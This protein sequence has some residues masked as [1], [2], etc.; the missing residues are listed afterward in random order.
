MGL[1]RASS[2]AVVVGSST[3]EI[4]GHDTLW[5]PESVYP[6]AADLYRRYRKDVL[7]K[8]ESPLLVIVSGAGRLDLS[9]TAFHTEGQRVLIVTSE[10]GKKNLQSGPNVSASVQVRAVS[11][12][13]GRLAPSAILKLLREEFNVKLALNE[14]GPTLFGQFLAA[15]L[16]DELFLTV[17]PQ[18]AGRIPQ[19][20]R[21]SFVEGVDFLPGNA[22]WWQLLSAKQAGNHLYLH[23]HRNDALRP[24]VAG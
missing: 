22:P 9:R 8:S 2:D 1:L 14:G 16:V 15:G 6:P 17:A 7:K 4:A 24:S 3:F 18:I 20:P 21:P 11:A 23:Y 10:E 5:F 19:H 12:A 13:Q